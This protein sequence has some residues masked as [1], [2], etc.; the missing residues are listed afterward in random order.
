[1]SRD[2]VTSFTLWAIP[3]LGLT[4]TCIKTITFNPTPFENWVGGFGALLI[5]ALIVR[6]VRKESRHGNDLQ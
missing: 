6:T 2:D 4:A 5:V 1:M 3:T